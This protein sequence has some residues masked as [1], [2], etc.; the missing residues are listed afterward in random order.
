MTIVQ[1]WNSIENI[2]CTN[3][4]EWPMFN[5]KISKKIFAVH[6]HV[7]YSVQYQNSKE[8]IRCTNLCEYTISSI[9][10]AKKTFAVQTYLNVQYRNSKENIRCTN[11]CAFSMISSTYCESSSPTVTFRYQWNL[12]EYPISNIKTAKKTFYVQTYVNVQCAIMK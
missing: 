6:T 9:K 5:I 11:L 2:L 4:C 8:I 12:C 3:L 7:N 1:Y 10:I